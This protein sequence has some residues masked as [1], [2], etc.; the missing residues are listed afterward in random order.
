[1]TIEEYEAEVLKGKLEWQEEY[2]KHFKKVSELQAGDRIRFEYGDFDKV[3]DMQVSK[4]EGTI[5]FGTVLYTNLTITS[6][7]AEEYIDF[8]YNATVKILEG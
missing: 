7:G 6:I 3:I 8:G 4:V 2:K 5:V 1:M